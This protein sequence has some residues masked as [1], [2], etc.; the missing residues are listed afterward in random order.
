LQLLGILSLVGVVIVAV[1]L[2]ELVGFIEK[3]TFGRLQKWA[4]RQQQNKPWIL[5]NEDSWKDER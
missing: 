5:E 2:W 3:E 4:S 1:L